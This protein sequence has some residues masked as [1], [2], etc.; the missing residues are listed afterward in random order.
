MA[1]TKLH[2]LNYRRTAV[3]KATAVE[4]TGLSFQPQGRPSHP[5]DSLRRRQFCC[6][7]HS[8]VEDFYGDASRVAEQAGAH[9]VLLVL[10]AS[11]FVHVAERCCVLDDPQDFRSTFTGPLIRLRMAAR[12]SPQH[13]ER[14]AA[15]LRACFQ[16]SIDASR[17]L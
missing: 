3:D 12:L 13:R 17:D 5:L 10:R 4:R 9:R 15:R 2:V 8:D 16:E 7:L 1:C 11:R 6:V 14:A